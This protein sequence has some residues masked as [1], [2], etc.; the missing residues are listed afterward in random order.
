MVH[1]AAS[2]RLGLRR[3]VAG[4][5]SH[6]QHY[7]ERDALRRVDRRLAVDH[8]RRK[9][10]C[11]DGVCNNRQHR[12]VGHALC[13]SRLFANGIHAREMGHVGRR[14][15]NFVFKEPIS[16]N[17]GRRALLV[18]DLDCKHFDGLLRREWGCHGYWWLNF[19]HDGR[20]AGVA[21][22]N[23]S[24]RILVCRMVHSIERRYTGHDLV[25]ARP[26]VEFHVVCAVDGEFVDGDV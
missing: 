1:D 25:S 7:F 17:A 19:N 4:R 24:N 14:F 23:V 5:R 11:R 15:R 21:W 16:V 6:I 12:C 18:R 2:R 3:N 20:N 8:I 26:D 9:R 10:R 13:R 22:D